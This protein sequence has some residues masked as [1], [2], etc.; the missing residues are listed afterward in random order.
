[1]RW[2]TYQSSIQKKLEFRSG[3]NVKKSVNEM[4][5][6]VTLYLDTSIPNALFKEPKEKKKRPPGPFHKYYPR[7]N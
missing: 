7:E 1:M 2:N 4:P 6:K 5:R 3:A